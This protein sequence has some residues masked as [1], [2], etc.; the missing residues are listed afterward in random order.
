MMVRSCLLFVLLAGCASLQNP[1]RHS[2]RRQHKPAPQ[3][4]SVAPE[5]AERDRC[6][7]SQTE[8]QTAITSLQ[9]GY[10]LELPGNDWSASC[11]AGKPLRASSERGYQITVM[12]QR[13]ATAVDA[14]SYLL[15]VGQR[16]SRAMQRDGLSPSAL[17]LHAGS[18]HDLPFVCLSVEKDA[19]RSQQ[20][21]TTRPL[22]D[23]R[24]LDLHV[25]WTGPAS[26]ASDQEQQARAAIEQIVRRFY[27]VDDLIATTA[28]AK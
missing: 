14:S 1:L 28:Q 18:G 6:S 12:A 11:T 21:W 15:H 10:A 13:P 5:R 20:C 3:A 26:E 9:D 27:L 22:T 16:V 25:S 19:R 24:M 17:T 4:H 7:S 23:G 2:T 8:G